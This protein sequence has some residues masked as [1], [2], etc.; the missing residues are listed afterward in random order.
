MV[1]VLCWSGLVAVHA[2]SS[3]DLISVDFRD[4]DV[5]QVLRVIDLHMKDAT[6]IIDEDIHGTVTI[7]FANASAKQA[8]DQ[9][10]KATGLT[11]RP[12]QG[13]KIVHVMK[14]TSLAT[15]ER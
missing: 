2:A 9:I 14:S 8:L 3:P 13:G 15:K 5:R 11:Y 1:L 10:M 4:A 7:R 6:F 12:E